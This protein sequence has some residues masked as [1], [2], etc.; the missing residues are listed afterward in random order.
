MRY[1]YFSLLCSLLCGC[2]ATY[3]EPH[4]IAL[5]HKVRDE[6]I[7]DMV[8]NNSFRVCAIGGALGRDVEEIT[9][10][11]VSKQL[12]TVELARIQFVLFGEEF[13]RRL[14]G[15]EEIR[16][17]LHDYPA[18]MKNFDLD[19]MYWDH[20]NNFVSDGY[21]ALM[22][23]CKGKIVYKAF[24]YEKDDFEKIYEEPYDEAVRIVREEYP[25]LFTTPFHVESLGTPR[26]SNY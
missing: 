9:I 4:Y 7:V 12:A 14:N 5:A 19:F 15:W 21:V 1:L 2:M 11:F 24:N 3:P 23:Y 22:F 17:Y 18:T 6:F 20:E 10:G 16:P 26:W 13:L 8:R 25:W